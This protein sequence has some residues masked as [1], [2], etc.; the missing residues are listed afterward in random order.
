MSDTT[1]AAT[2]TSN[3]T[4]LYLSRILGR[5]VLDAQGK[6]VATVKDLVVRF[7]SEPYPVVSGLVARQGNR[8]FYLDRA[9]VADISTRGARLAT[10]KVDLR[11]FERREGEALLRRDILD[12]QLID[13]D[14]RR[15][16]RA[17]DLVLAYIDGQ[18][19]L[20]GVDVS[21]QG[22]LRRLGPAALTGNM[23][24]RRII[25]WEDV[26]SFATDV[27][28][29]RLR[30]SHEGVARLH[31]VEIAHILDSLSF[32]QGQEILEALDDETAADTIQEMHPDEAADLMEGLDRERAADILDEMDPD[33]AAD[34]LADMSAESAEELLELMEPEESEDVRE[35]LSYEEDTAAGLMTTDYVALPQDLTAGE[36]LARL[37]ALEEPPDPLYHLY[38]VDAEGSERLVGVAP[39][40]DVVLAAPDTPLTAL[41]WDEFQSARL[42]EPSR[43]VA[44]KMAEYSLAALPVVDEGGRIMGIVLVD[45]AMDVLV[46]DLSGRRLSRVFH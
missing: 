15:L 5:P 6:R 43:D 36:A 31:P 20:V 3:R 35:L 10:Y 44:H 28:M 24:S 29:V 30:T 19:R 12:K 2:Q 1:A 39:L 25:D 23:E 41:A 42:D 26:E 37:R 8:D 9:Q 27:P 34:L 13:V 14:G 38:L 33:D 22:I 32:R 17:N 40:R 7:G 4:A 16:I 11:P 21:V 46:P 18:Y 45:D